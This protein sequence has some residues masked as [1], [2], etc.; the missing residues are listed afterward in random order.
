MKLN[1]TIISCAAS[2]LVLAACSAPQ[3]QG[4]EKVE[5]PDFRH[6]VIEGDADVNLVQGDKPEISSR[7]SV[8]EGYEVK[9]DTLVVGD[10]YDDLKVTVCNLE[11]ITITGDGDVTTKGWIESVSL[12]LYANGSGDIEGNFRANDIVLKVEADG[13]ADLKVDCNNLTVVAVG[14][15][16]VELKGKCVNYSKRE[17]GFSGIDSRGLAAEC[18]KIE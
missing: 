16:D 14:T 6:I 17:A 10:C 9:S 11:S 18:I 4:K 7:S 15:G 2:A 5:I 3:P 12:A 8:G 13:D 1:K